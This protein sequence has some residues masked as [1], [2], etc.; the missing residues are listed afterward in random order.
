MN[1]TGRVSMVLCLAT[2]LILVTVLPA[3]GLSLQL[4]GGDAGPSRGAT[5]VGDTLQPPGVQDYR[6]NGTPYL[7]SYC[8][9]SAFCMHPGGVA[10]VGPGNVVILTETTNYFADQGY[11]GQNAVVMFNAT[12]GL[13]PTP[14]PLPCIPGQP[15][16]PGSGPDV[17]VPCST[18]SATAGFLFVIDWQTWEPVLNVSFPFKPNAID[19]S[20]LRGL[21]YISNFTDE[22]A[23]ID[24]VTGAIQTLAT[25]ANASMLP[26]YWIGLANFFHTLAFDPASDELIVPGLSGGLLI[27]NS[28][29]FSVVRGIAVPGN[30]TS[31]TVDDGDGLVLVSTVVAGTSS[32]FVLNSLSFQQVSNLVLP[33]CPASTPCPGP[34]PVDQVVVDP[35][36]GD[37]YVV[38]TSLIAALNLSELEFVGTVDVRNVFGAT[39]SSTYAPTVDSLY[40]TLGEFPQY[41]PGILVVLERSP[42]IS[43]G[44]S[45]LPLWILASSVAVGVA[46][47]VVLFLWPHAKGRLGR[48]GEL[49]EPLER[50]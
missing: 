4:P 37:A 50:N 9:T 25:V 10:Y 23:S 47:G 27:L 35:T 13:G 8:P 20:S 18:Q 14:L 26:S 43:T 42:A 44:V 46:A 16:Y 28:T 5:P 7:D 40:G 48:D 45:T 33:G 22:F 6:V 30:I 17:F 2:T 34:D 31:I 1:A 21:V 38:A 49:R 19:Y 36:H 32:L 3:V 24:P 11:P 15:L 41:S 12:T 29:T 39:V